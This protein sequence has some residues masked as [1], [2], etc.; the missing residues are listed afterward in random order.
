VAL[1]TDLWQLPRAITAFRRKGL[2]VLPIAVEPPL[3]PSQRNRLALRD[4]A[5]T[6]LYGLQGRM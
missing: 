4:T 6:V 3:S 5:A 1:I 2:V